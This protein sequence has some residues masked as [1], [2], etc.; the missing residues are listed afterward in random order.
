LN[1]SGCFK[2][3]GPQIGSRLQTSSL[4]INFYGI[5]RNAFCGA[6]SL[7]AAS[8][9]SSPHLPKATGYSTAGYLAPFF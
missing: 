2:K 8:P 6:I 3:I 9:I 7:F 4:I 1:I 5:K